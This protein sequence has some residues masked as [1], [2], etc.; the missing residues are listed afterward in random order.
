ME[1]SHCHPLEGGTGTAWHR[2]GEQPLSPSGRWH[3]HCLAQGWME[4]SHCHPLEGGTGTA[5]AQGWMESSHCH[6]LEGGTG[7]AW[8]R[9]GWRAA[10]ATLWK[11]ARALPGTG[12]ESS[13]CHPL[14]GGTGTAWH[15]DGEQ[16]LPPSGRWHRHCL[17]QGWMES[18][19]CHPLEGGTGT[20]LAQGW[21]ESSHCHPLEGG[22][23]TAWHRDG[24]Q[25]LPP[26]GRWHGHC[27]AQGWRAAIATLWKVAQAL[28][29]TGMES[30][31]CHPLEGGTGTALAQGGMESSHCHPLEGGTGAARPW[32]GCRAVSLGVTPPCP[33]PWEHPVPVP[34]GG[35]HCC[36]PAR[37]PP[38]ARQR[39]QAGS[40]APSWHLPPCSRRAGD[41]Q[42]HFYLWVPAHGEDGRKSLAPSGRG[43]TGTP[44]LELLAAGP[45]AAEP[46]PK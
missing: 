8:H 19:H 10:I 26:S 4:S 16:P 25:P 39:L 9:D 33:L 12:M 21:M 43:D 24:E 46:G 34:A 7:T 18:S 31:H 5:L 41:A 32:Q 28:P 38:I 23:G 44:R 30:S 40:C 29:G 45:G 42:P 27:L 37:A 2:D 22:T 13:H 15:R 6:P 1:S 14:E 11:V 20:A 35:W 36:Q 17:A 3:G